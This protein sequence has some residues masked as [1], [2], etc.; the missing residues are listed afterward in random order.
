VWRKHSGGVK[1]RDCVEFFVDIVKVGPGSCEDGSP[2]RVN[3]SGEEY[4]SVGIV[5]DC[6]KIRKTSGLSDEKWED[7]VN[8][9]LELSIQCS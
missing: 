7:V 6:P 1:T 8:F 2:V 3:A 4:G 9:K 5:L